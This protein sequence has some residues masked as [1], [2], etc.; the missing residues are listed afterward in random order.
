MRSAVGGWSCFINFAIVAKSFIL[1]VIF[2]WLALSFLKGARF[3]FILGLMGPGAVF[4]TLSGSSSVVLELLDELL[5][6]VLLPELDLFLL[7]LFLDFLECFL[8]FFIFFVGVVVVGAEV[9][10]LSVLLRKLR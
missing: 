8:A 1:P 2:V 5:E 3:T 6:E 4:T 10:G 7:F 9:V